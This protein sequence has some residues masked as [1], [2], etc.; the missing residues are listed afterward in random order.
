MFSE[1]ISL[2]KE[3]RIRIWKLI[4]FGL[5]FLVIAKNVFVGADMDEG[6]AIAAAYRIVQ[7]DT[8]ILKMWEPHQTSAIFTAVFIKI[9][10]IFTGGALT[11]LN[12]CLRA[13]YFVIQALT[14]YAFY[15]TLLKVFGRLD[16]EF[17][18]LLSALFFVTSPKNIYIPEYSNLHIWFLTG[19]VLCLLN[20]YE[21]LSSGNKSYRY[22][23]AAGVFL[24]FDVLAYPDMAFLYPVCL[25]VFFINRK[26]EK[27]GFLSE[28][29]AFTIP[30]VLGAGLFFLYIGMHMSYDDAVYAIGHILNEESHNQGITEKLSDWG[31]S[32]AKEIGI[33]LATILLSVL[34]SRYIKK[35]SL[36]FNLI[37]LNC[38]FQALYYVFGKGNCQFPL[39]IYAVPAFLGIYF[40]EKRICKQLIAIVIVNFILVMLLSNWEPALLNAYFVPGTIL[41]YAAIQ[42]FYVSEGWQRDERLGNISLFVMLITVAFGHVFLLLGGASDHNTLL[43]VGGIYK[44]GFRKGILSDY[45]SAYRYNSN[46]GIWKEAV[47]EGCNV[48][49]VGASQFY[50]M[51]GDNVQASPNTICSYAYAPSMTDYWRENPERLPDIVV[52]ETEYGDLRDHSEDT[53]VYKWITGDFG[54]ASYEDYPFI[55]VYRR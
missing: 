28:A 54:A 52:V 39:L 32:F 40:S 51:F 1:S 35:S 45:M 14:S 30:C 5:L 3:Y 31:L 33:I 20:Y 42:N 9:F 44:S 46:A 4:L 13:V 23:F 37:I 11:Y 41:G 21:E 18:I 8:L 53:Y 34:I 2:G 15:K 55:R 47:P 17:A 10:T 26:Q 22:V 7:G 12:L 48:F 29:A 49:Y 50:V 43:D 25:A 38:I 6:Y 24:T 16:N 27:A 19:L 36:I